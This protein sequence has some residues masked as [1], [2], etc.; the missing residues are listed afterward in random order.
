MRQEPLSRSFGLVSGG[1]HIIKCV[2]NAHGNAKGRADRY[3]LL[4]ACIAHSGLVHLLYVRRGDFVRVQ[5]ERFEK[6]KRSPQPVVQWRRA[7]VCQNR[8]NEIVVL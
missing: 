6:G 2:R 5:G 8:F 3:G 1:G 4:Y 7:P